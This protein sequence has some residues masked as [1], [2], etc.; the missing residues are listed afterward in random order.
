MEELIAC[1]AK[2]II[3]FGYAGSL[4][5]AAPI[6]SIIIPTSCVSDEGTSKHYMD[7]PHLAEA[8]TTLVDTLQ[9]ACARAGLSVH[10]GRHWT[11]DAVYRERIDHVT[12]HAAE[13]VLGV[14]MET[15]AMYTLGH[16]RDVRVCNV[17]VVSDELWTEWNPGFAGDALRLAK[18]ALEDVL[19]DVLPRL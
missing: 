2:T 19:I 5:Q 3:G 6:G 8:D 14:D 16:V 4:Q 18:T 13:G 9:K 7:Q 1:G 10:V 17:L 12:S 15:S 11:T